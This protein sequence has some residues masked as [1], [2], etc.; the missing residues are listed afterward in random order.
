MGCHV[1][2][3]QCKSSPPEPY[4]EAFYGFKRVQRQTCPMSGL[5]C[6]AQ[7]SD[8]VLSS[9]PGNATS[10][11]RPTPAV[12]A[13]F[14]RCVPARMTA[15]HCSGCGPRQLHVRTCACPSSACCQSLHC[16]SGGKL[17]AHSEGMAFITCEQMLLS[18]G[19]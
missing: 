15:T 3:L 12:C 13:C 10:T 14:E 17:T 7:R 18:A 9:T 1:F 5:T 6:L 16:T 4:P 11:K 8:F 19:W 2:V